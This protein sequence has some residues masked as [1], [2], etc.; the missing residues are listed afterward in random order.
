MSN[1]FW[2]DAQMDLK[3]MDFSPRGCVKFKRILTSVLFPDSPFSIV[4]REKDGQDHYEN[5]RLHSARITKQ[6]KSP[7]H[8]WENDYEI[9]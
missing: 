9:I 3:K 4:R 8:E 1:Q 7:I 2:N 5:P 6:I